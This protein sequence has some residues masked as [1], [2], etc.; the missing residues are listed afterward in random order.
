[1]SPLLSHERKVL[2][3]TPMISRVVFPLT[4]SLK[5]FVCLFFKE[6]STMNKQNSVENYV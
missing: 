3:E 2:E 5:R 4:H 6:C 1:M